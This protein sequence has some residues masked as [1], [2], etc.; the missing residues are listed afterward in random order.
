MGFLSSIMSFGASEIETHS[1]LCPYDRHSIVEKSS[2][3]S[4]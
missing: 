2:F 1:Q 4:S 3:V